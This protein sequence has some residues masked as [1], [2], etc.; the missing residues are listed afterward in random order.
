MVVFSMFFFYEFKW[1]ECTI[2]FSLLP[3]LYLMRSENESD[4]Y[5]ATHVHLPYLQR[6]I[7]K[8]FTISNR[9]GKAKEVT[10]RKHEVTQVYHLHELYSA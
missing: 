10:Q 6:E 9:T 2:D 8:Q 1:P 7:S 5:K 4:K 3:S